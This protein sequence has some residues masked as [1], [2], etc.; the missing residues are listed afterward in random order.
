MATQPAQ[1]THRVPAAAAWA[2]VAIIAPAC[3]IAVGRITPASSFLAVAAIAMLLGLVVA[4]WNVD[5]AWTM[6]G[7]IILSM[8]NG[9]WQEFGLPPL[10]TPDR[11]LLFLVIIMVVVRAPV[12]RNRPA[13]PF[14][15]AHLWI[16]LAAAISIISADTAGTLF[17]GDGGGFMLT[18]RFGLLP[19]AAFVVAPVVFS[20]PSQRRVLF[21]TL[22]VIGAYLA[23]TA[24]FEIVGPRSLVFPRYV[25]DPTLTI[26][27]GRARGPFVNS[28]FDGFGIYIGGI[29]AILLA[30]TS[31][32]KEVRLLG[33]CIAVLCTVGLL[34][35]LTR[36]VWLS[37]AVAAVI[38]A[39]LVREA[40][41]WLP[42]AGFAACLVAL[43]TV[44]LVPGLG[45]TASARLNDASTVYQ[46]ETLLR[47]SVKMVEAR[48][49]FGFGWGTFQTA[50]QPYYIVGQAPAFLQ[51]TEPV[52]NVYASNLAEL[53]L[54]GT[55]VWLIA[56]AVA[57]ASPLRRH[58][59]G[60]ARVW[61]ILLGTTLVF[62]LCMATAS[63]M[64]GLF[65]H[66]VLWTL[67]GVYLAALADE[68]NRAR[69]RTVRPS[70]VVIGFGANGNTG[71]VP[72]LSSRSNADTSSGFG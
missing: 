34:L 67:G 9:H 61:K 63:P 18:D 72:R 44:T 5:P 70:P 13:I 39:I 29:A 68:S 51:S 15:S 71:A 41:R 48:P 59:R 7:A 56:G 35:T 12:L 10:V 28:S 62:Y 19:F 32:R 27:E 11:F 37:A 14:G 58:A 69:P 22:G 42:A 21:I 53:G 54:V 26:H 60:E 23:G 50:S 20:T 1:Q 38:T 40:R 66:L 30:A 45:S 64:I 49:L 25:L 52:H 24:V 46:R 65:A 55:G 4:L 6:S 33:G 16:L 17:T 47:A 57:L 3:G 31:R 8:F 36:S 43:A 2:G